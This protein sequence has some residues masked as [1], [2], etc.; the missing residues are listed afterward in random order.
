[1]EINKLRVIS[2]M[3]NVFKKILSNQPIKPEEAKKVSSFILG[4]WLSGDARLM[5]LANTLN[6][7]DSKSTKNLFEENNLVL[8]EAIR[9]ALAGKIRYIKYPSSPKSKPQVGEEYLTMCKH[10]AKYFNVSL[11]EAMEYHDWY[12]RHCPDEHQT[13]KIIFKL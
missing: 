11:D 10:I 12:S 1:M 4:R 9:L 7:L 6:T 3:F 5:P 2:K 13:L 8:L